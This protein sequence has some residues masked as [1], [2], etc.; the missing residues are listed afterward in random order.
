MHEIPFDVN[1]RQDLRQQVFSESKLSQ[2]RRERYLI[3]FC[4]FLTFEFVFV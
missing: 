4:S 2:I 1:L 3:K